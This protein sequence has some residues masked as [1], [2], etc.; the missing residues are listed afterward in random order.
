MVA[1]TFR[2]CDEWWAFDANMS[3]EGVS[4]RRSEVSPPP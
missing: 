3:W 1:D 4:Q 2:S